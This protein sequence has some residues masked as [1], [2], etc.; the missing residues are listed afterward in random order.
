[1]H[2]SFPLIIRS[3]AL[4]FAAALPLSGAETPSAATP[5]GIAPD[6]TAPLPDPLPLDTSP[7]NAPAADLPDDPSLLPPPGAIQPSATPSGGPSRNFSINLLKRLV[8]RGAL[9]RK[10]AE[11]LIQF[12]DADVIAASAPALMPAPAPLPG[13]VRVTYVPETVR[14]RMRDEIRDQLRAEAKAEGWVGGKQGL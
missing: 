8:E 4:L 2:S 7:L 14:N 10:D 5:S 13:E 3:T 12:A 1:M 6:A 9:T 11:E